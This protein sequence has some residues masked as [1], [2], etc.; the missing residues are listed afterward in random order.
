MIKTSSIKPSTGLYNRIRRIIESARG[1]V[2][3]SV[4]FEMVQAYWLI[5]REI[6]I[7]EQKGK[8]RA[9]YGSRILRQLSVRLTTDFGAGFDESNLRNMRQFFLMYPKRDALRHELSW[10]QY[11]ILMRVEKPE[12]RSFYEIECVKNNWSAR[13]L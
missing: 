6:V 9:E 5:G 12:A 7:E 11:R 2:M 4:N 8:T 10:T 1:N 3:R 13:E